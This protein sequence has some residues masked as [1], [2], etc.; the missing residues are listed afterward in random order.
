VASEGCAGVR[1]DGRDS[2]ASTPAPVSLTFHIIRNKSSMCRAEYPTS[3]ASPHNGRQQV[4]NLLKAQDG[5]LR[6][7]SQHSVELSLTL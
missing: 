5:F 4:S 3:E 1:Q 2:R 6:P 7:C